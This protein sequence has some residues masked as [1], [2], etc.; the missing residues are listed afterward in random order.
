MRLSEVGTLG[1]IEHSLH[2]PDAA[3][4]QA[5]YGLRLQRVWKRFGNFVAVRDISFA[6]RTSVAHREWPF[7]SSLTWTVKLDDCLH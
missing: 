5:Q 2:A 1:T 6:A 7:V 4:G 3:E